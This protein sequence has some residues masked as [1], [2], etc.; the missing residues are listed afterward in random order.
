[1]LDPVEFGKS[2]GL[3]V[4]NAI[5]P[6]L[7]RIEE[8]E[9]RQLVKGDK[10]DAGPPGNDA[11]PLDRAQIVKE[12]SDVFAEKFEDWKKAIVL[13]KGDRGD[14]G[15]PGKDADPILVKDV[16][17]EL[18][19]CPE[20][21]TLVDLHA[22]AAV[23]KHF[24][25]NPVKHGEPGAKGEKGERGDEGKPGADGIGQ[26]GAMIDR[27]GHLIITTTKGEAVRLGVVVGKDGAPGKDG[28]D[29][30]D[31]EIDYDGERT[32]TVKNKTGGV[33]VKRLPIPLDKGYWRE[34]MACEKGDIVTQQ[35]NA[36]IALR[37]TKAKPCIENADDWR[38]FARK[39]KDGIDG[40]PGRDLGPPQPVKLSA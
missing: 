2:M 12:V 4:S 22:A 8:L 13:P 24:E 20:I 27:D 14:A 32:L 15:A 31:A 37:D 28:Q 30:S 7:K 35:G 18:L 29:F 40:K 16:V 39:G 19:E 23:H 5:A 36:F 3:L 17:A 21:N 25:T 1:M 34:G 11:P 9:A 10:G 6:L 26:A 33:I 38:L